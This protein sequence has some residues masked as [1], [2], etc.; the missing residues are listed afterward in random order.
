MKH[1]L[2]EPVEWIWKARWTT[3]NPGD[4]E[5]F[6]FRQRDF[7]AKAREFRASGINVVVIAGGFHFRWNFAPE[8]PA[9]TRMVRKIT[10]A[11]HR[12]GIKLVEHHSAIGCCHPI[13]AQEYAQLNEIMRRFKVDIARHPG[14]AQIL[15]DGDY[16]YQG[17]P[18]NAMRQIDPRTG[19]YAR[20]LYMSYPFCHNNPDWQR[21]YFDYLR[22]LYACGVDGIMS[23]DVGFWLRNYACGCRHCREKF[24]RDTGY[25][26]PPTGMDDPEFYGN[27][28]T[29]AGRAWVLWRIRCHREHQQRVVSHFRGLGLD[30]ARPI[31]CSSATNSFGPRGLGSAMDDLDGCYSLMF[32]EV[33]T[34]DVQ[35]HGWLRTGAEASHR[36]ALARRNG[37]PAMT[38]FFPHNAKENLF[39]WGMTKVWGHQYRYR[40]QDTDK[41]AAKSAAAILAGPYKFEERYPALYHRPASVAEVGVL[42]SARTS[43]LHKDDDGEPDYIRMSDPA[44][45]DCWAGWCEVLMLARIPFDTIGENDL[46]EHKYFDRLRLII[47]PNAVCM[48]D[49]AVA[50]LKEFVR[51]GG[52][53]IITHQ[54]GLKDE[55]GVRRRRYPLAGLVGADYSGISA[56]SPDWVATS[57]ASLTVKRCSCRRYPVALFKLRKRATPWMKLAGKAAPAVFHSRYG[58][59]EV[60][61]CAGKPGR[62]VCINRHRRRENL[63]AVKA[64]KRYAEIDFSMHPQVKSLMLSMVEKML[65]DSPLRTT[66]MPEGFVTGLFANG[67]RRVL[68]IINAAGTLADNGRVVPIPAP[69]R[70]PRAETLPGGAATMRLSVRGLFK[71]AILRSPEKAG[72]KSLKVCQHDG[73]TDVELPSKYISCYSVIELLDS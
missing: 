26:I 28:E 68:H 33:I 72:E 44:H 57:A 64:E 65:T 66:G 9:I 4:A 47:V 70:F 63:N 39:C 43:W 54:S 23:D 6:E 17:V 1:L 49:K 22:E 8:W 55:T 32:T 25:S 24:Q 10:E 37:V 42:F 71:R 20:S 53:V 40:A 59:G 60:L 69:L 58:K 61:V 14:M 2:T 41:P 36:S 29:P 15:R 48:S 7:D 45:T 51:R 52:R 56:T 67:Q 18:Y 30:L 13:G 21:L 27:L 35:A 38:L 31:Y 19:N 3:W 73:Y 62:I 11:C 12:H 50:A 34:M 16:A 46:E 5:L